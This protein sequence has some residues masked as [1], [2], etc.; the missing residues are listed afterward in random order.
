MHDAGALSGGEMRPQRP[1]T[2][3]LR[4][5]RL[6]QCHHVMGLDSLGSSGRE[7]DDQSPSLAFPSSPSWEGEAGKTLQQRVDAPWGGRVG[8]GGAAIPPRA[9]L[10]RGCSRPESECLYPR[11]P[12]P[13]KA[14]FCPGLC[15]LCLGKSKQKLELEGP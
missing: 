15:L 12:S 7:P 14:R 1:D 4:F 10:A 13:K 2:P 11:P 6:V 8:P 9:C 5:L 3:Q